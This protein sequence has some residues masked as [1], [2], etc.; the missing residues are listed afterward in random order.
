MEDEL[1]GILGRMNE[2]QEGHLQG[3]KAV[4]GVGPAGECGSSLLTWP[5]AA[6]G[7]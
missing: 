7:S 5:L 4:R 6:M 1:N 2:S 3:D